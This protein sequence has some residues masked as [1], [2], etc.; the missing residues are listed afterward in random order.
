MKLQKQSE[1]KARTRTMIQA[2]GLLQKSGLMEAFQISSGEDL[3][4]YENREK[5]NRLFGFLIE[6][7]EKNLFNEHN[8]EKWQDLGKRRL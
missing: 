3:Q 5:A 1:R 4:D 2:A 6:S 7:F 8:F